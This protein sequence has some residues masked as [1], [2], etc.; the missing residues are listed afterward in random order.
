MFY[1]YLQGNKQCFMENIIGR[2][3]EVQELND[4][5]TS[6]KAQLVTVY[7][8]G[9]LEKLSMSMKQKNKRPNELPAVGTFL[10]FYHTSTRLALGTKSGSFF[11]MLKASYQA[12]MWGSAPFTRQRPAECG[13]VLVSLRSISSRTLLAQRRE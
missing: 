4:L 2:K 6:N 5:Y 7:G 9:E 10:V 12:S 3:H 13:S 11:L 8:D 1:I